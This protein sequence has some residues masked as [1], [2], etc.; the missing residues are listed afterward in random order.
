ATTPGPQVMLIQS[1]FRHLP[2]G[3][4]TVDRQQ[5]ADYFIAELERRLAEQSANLVVLPE[6][7]F[8]PLNDEARRELARSPIGPSLETN[9]QRLMKIAAD[10]HTALLLGGNAVTGWTTQGTEHVGSEIRNSAYFFAPQ[11]KQPLSRYDKI[12]L[13]RFSERAPLTIGP[14]WLRRIATFI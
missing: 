6:A 12:Y 14:E 2:G 7:A 8:P 3:A 11:T 5:A 9:Y 1:N 4:P 10:H 13:A